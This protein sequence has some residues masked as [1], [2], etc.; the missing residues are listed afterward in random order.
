MTK[1]SDRP[2]KYSNLIISKIVRKLQRKI[3]IAL[4]KFSHSTKQ[5]WL[6]RLLTDSYREV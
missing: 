1:L 2:E 4:N 6:H 3:M 5:D